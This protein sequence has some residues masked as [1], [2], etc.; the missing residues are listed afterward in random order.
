MTA[1]GEGGVLLASQG[2]LPALQNAEASWSEMDPNTPAWDVAES[3]ETGESQRQTTSET[4]NF[5]LNLFWCGIQSRMPLMIRDHA[6]LELQMYF[7]FSDIGVFD[8]CCSWGHCRFW[9]HC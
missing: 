4:R 1:G 7:Y 8:N 9:S 2:G 6:V 5:W 3:G